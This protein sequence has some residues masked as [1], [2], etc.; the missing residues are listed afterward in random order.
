[1]D[2]SGSESAC[3]VCKELT[4]PGEDHLSCNSTLNLHSFFQCICCLGD[5][6]VGDHSECQE[7]IAK[8]RYDFINFLRN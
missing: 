2:Y 1:M 6:R 3:N 4:L 8:F 7:R 5:E